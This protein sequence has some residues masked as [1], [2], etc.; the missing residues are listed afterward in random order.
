MTRTRR[1]SARSAPPERDG[2]RS[3]RHGRSNRAVMSTGS[4]RGRDTT[5]T[6]TAGTVGRVAEPAPISFADDTRTRLHDRLLAA[7]ADLLVD[8]RWSRVTM[9]AVAARAGVSRQTLYN[10]LGSRAALAEAL[11]LR[12][13]DRMLAVADSALSAGR[14]DPP[15]AIGAAFAGFL[16]EAASSPIVRALLDDDAGD[17]LLPLI[18]S[19]GAPLLAHASDT[20]ADVVLRIW[21]VVA[22]DRA[23]ELAELVVRLALSYTTLPPAAPHATAGRIAEMLRPYVTEVVGGAV[24][25]RA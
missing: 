15:A 5:A 20:L 25:P 14:A 13:V 6:A 1:S 16:D 21:P 4:R 22:R 17:S 24:A 8:L 23:R 19:R 11:A 3:G 12:E 9:A 18:T 7:A 10:E 2:L